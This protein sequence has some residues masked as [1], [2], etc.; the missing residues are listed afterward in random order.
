V[1]TVDLTVNLIVK[2]PDYSSTTFMSFMSVKI[3]EEGIT[4]AMSI[5]SVRLKMDENCIDLPSPL[6]VNRRQAES[7]PDPRWPEL[8]IFGGACSP[9]NSDGSWLLTT[10]LLSSLRNWRWSTSKPEAWSVLSYSCLCKRGYM[11]GRQ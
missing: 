10:S 9:A 11:A 3:W 8:S 6:S 1:I 2:I 5:R 4:V 7:G